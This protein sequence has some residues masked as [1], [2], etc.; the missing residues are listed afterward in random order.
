MYGILLYSNSTAL[1]TLNSPYTVKLEQVENWRYY[2]ALSSV[3][4]SWHSIPLRPLIGNFRFAQADS[5]S[6]VWT[7]VA[8]STKFS[9]WTTMWWWVTWLGRWHSRLSYAPQSLVYTALVGWRHLS[10][11]GNSVV[12]LITPKTDESGARRALLYCYEKIKRLYTFYAKTFK[13]IIFSL[14]GS[15]LTMICFEIF[16]S[17]IGHI[18][19]QRSWLSEVLTIFLIAGK[20]KGTGKWFN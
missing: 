1:V 15:L 7:P 20:K 6:C 14:L 9:R 13:S 10:K 16:Y 5:A 19:V 3:C 11:I 4:K 2:L 8:G 17:F 18:K 12:V